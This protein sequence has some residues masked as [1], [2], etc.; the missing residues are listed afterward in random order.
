ML[1]INPTLFTKN[2]R[3]YHATTV[4]EKRAKIIQNP[5]LGSWMQSGSAV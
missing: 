5:N 2:P 1:K 3:T 4:E